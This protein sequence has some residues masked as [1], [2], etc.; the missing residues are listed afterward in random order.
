MCK[1]KKFKHIIRDLK[2]PKP[3]PIIK[4]IL[5]KLYSKGFYLSYGHL[6]ILELW[7][8]YKKGLCQDFYDFVYEKRIY[9]SP[10]S[11]RNQIVQLRRMGVVVKDG[12][13][14]IY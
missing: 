13:L 6:C 1:R 5:P 14:K 12:K 2:H 3:S 8:S 9:N 11:V 10:Q 7:L 4:M